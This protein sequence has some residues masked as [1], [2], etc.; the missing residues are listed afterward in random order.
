MYLYFILVS[1]KCTHIIITLVLA[2]M[3]IS[4]YIFN[5]SFNTFTNHYISNHNHSYVYL[6]Q[7]SL[8]SLKQYRQVLINQNHWFISKFCKKI[9]MKVHSCI[10]FKF[11]TFQGELTPSTVQFLYSNNAPSFALH[12]SHLFRSMQR[13]WQI[14]WCL[15]LVVST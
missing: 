14:L 7:Y 3:L 13:L 2:H 1:I 11:H 5:P 9:S 12:C 6:P 8:S 4:L 15:N 10:Y